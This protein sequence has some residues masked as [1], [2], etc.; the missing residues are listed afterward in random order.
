M[1]A[2]FWE[3]Y[4][5]PKSSVLGGVVPVNGTASVIYWGGGV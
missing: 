1:R 4:S 5:V 2:A 3:K